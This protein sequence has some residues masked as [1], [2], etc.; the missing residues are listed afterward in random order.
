MCEAKDRGER[1]QLD[2]K[3]KSNPEKGNGLKGE[4]EIGGGGVAK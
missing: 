1:M 2:E 4:E 3:I